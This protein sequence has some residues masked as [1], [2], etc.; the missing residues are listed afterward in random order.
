MKCRNFISG[1][2]ILARNHISESILHANVFSNIRHGVS[3]Y[4][5][6]DNVYT[7]LYGTAVNPY[8]GM[9]IIKCFILNGALFMTISLPLKNHRALNLALYGLFSYHLPTN[10][11]DEKSLSS[12]Y[13]KLQVS[14]PYLLLGDDQY[15]LLD[16]NFDRQVVQYDHM[17]V[18]QEPLLL[19]RR[20]DKNCYINII[21][22]ALAKVI[23]SMCMFLY[24]HKITVH[25]SLVTTSHYFYLLNIND[26]LTFTCG[27]YGRQTTCHSHSVSIIKRTD[28]C[29]CVIQSV[30]IQLI[31]SHSNCSYN[32]NFII[33]QTFNF[34]TEW[35]HN[36]AVMPYYRENEHLLCLPSKASIPNFT[37]IKSN[38]SGVFSVNTVPPI[39]VQ[40]LD[41]IIGDLKQNKIYLSKSE[42]IGQDI[43]FFNESIMDNSANKIEKL[44]IDSWFDEVAESSMI[45][46]FMSCIIALPAFILLGF[47]CFKQGKLRKLISLYMASLPAVNAAALDSI[48]N[49]G[50]IFQYLLSA[51]YILILLYAIVKMIIWGSHYFR[52]YQTTTHFMCQHEHDKVP[53]TA[54][55]LELST[56]SE[57]THV[58]IAHLNIP[59]TRLSVLETD[60]NAY[61]LVSGNWLYDFIKLL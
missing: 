23:T 26:E 43:I 28:A 7:L 16:N 29:D 47:L 37:V 25:A 56:M 5:P 1:L 46:I 51:I 61:Y 54:F 45:F 32:G 22:H 33:Y 50:N 48:C 20:T 49:T 53:S 17:Y 38:Q 39:S 2:H 13:T 40:R 31:G 18:K 57:I 34:V 6:K 36:K 9:E 11:S 60:H 12:S 59:I 21:E 35:L 4:L 14:H 42:K 41:T 58:H 30:E 8:Y 19:F 27:K 55:A 44:D 10:I 15:A 52:R 24:Y 3:Q